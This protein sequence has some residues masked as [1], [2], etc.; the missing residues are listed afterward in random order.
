MLHVRGADKLWALKSSLEIPL[1][2]IAGVR[3]DQEAARGWYHGIR[4][5]GTNVPGVITAGTFYQR[6]E[7]EV[8]SALEQGFRSG[9]W[10]GADAKAIETLLARRKTA[11]ASAYLIAALYAELGDRDQALRWLDT[12]YQE[13]APEM[14]G[15]KTDFALDPLRS[16]PRFAELLRKVGLPQ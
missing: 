8:A 13:R 5:P 2:H 3:A 16:D 14:E 11:Y 1:V 4:M 15:L 9:G 6:N 10:K 7:S 12:A